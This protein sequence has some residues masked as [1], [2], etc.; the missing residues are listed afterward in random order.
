MENKIGNF[1]KEKRLE[2][3]MTIEELANKIEV[4]EK[5]I[6]KW[7]NGEKI[8]DNVR[9]IALSAALR[10]SLNDIPKSTQKQETVDDIIGDLYKQFFSVPTLLLWAILSLVAF[11]I[12]NNGS[13][14]HFIA[15]LKNSNSIFDG[16]FFLYMGICLIAVVISLFI[17]TSF[18]TIKYDKL[19]RKL[20]KEN[21]KKSKK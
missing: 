16:S 3:N 1:L 4:T 5:H 13:L 21:R 6:S 11:N 7:E 20:E 19:I 8:P 12:C 14:E 18:H 10:F 17:Y 15:N 9:L 2:R